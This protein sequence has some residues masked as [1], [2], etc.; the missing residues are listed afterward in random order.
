MEACIQCVIDEL[1]AR[2]LLQHWIGNSEIWQGILIPCQP[3]RATAKQIP[4]KKCQG[5]QLGFRDHQALLLAPSLIRQRSLQVSVSG[6]FDF[7]RPSGAHTPWSRAPT[8]AV[9]AALELRDPSEDTLLARQ[10]IDLANDQQPGTVWHLQLGGVGGAEDKALLRSVSSIRWPSSPMDF[11]LIV[12]LALYLFHNSEWS[13]LRRTSP[14]R[15]FV[16]DSEMLVLSHYFDAFRSY[17]SQRHSR[18]SWLAEQCNRSG[19]VNP[20]PA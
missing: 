10:H 15:G 6:V 4:H 9:T 17:E 19:N 12:E 2:D 5:W 16:Q 7:R 20:K 13:A 11:I 1:G 14:W 3:C 8:Q 18:D